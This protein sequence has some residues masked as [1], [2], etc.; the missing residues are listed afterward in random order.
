[1]NIGSH[2]YLNWR[3]WA[4]SYGLATCISL[5]SVSV[6]YWVVYI[7]GLVYK[8]RRPQNILRGAEVLRDWSLITGRGGGYTTGGGGG[9]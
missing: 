9:M 3:K 5:G 8:P 2:V 4:V 7:Q 6:F 1:M